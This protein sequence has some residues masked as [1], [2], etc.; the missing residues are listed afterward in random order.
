MPTQSKPVLPRRSGCNRH[1]PSVLLEQ[2][3][4]TLSRARLE[5]PSIRM[6]SSWR[7]GCCATADTPTR[8]GNPAACD[9]RVRLSGFAE[10]GPRKAA[11]PCRGGLELANAGGLRTGDGYPSC[12]RFRFAEPCER[13]DR[14]SVDFDSAIRKIG[15]FRS[16]RE[17]SSRAHYPTRWAVE[18]GY[19]RP[20]RISSRS[21]NGKDTN[22]R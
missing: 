4:R 17:P 8:T 21:M 1:A 16:A 10:G 5:Q 11:R 7:I 14:L 20:R 2:K 13:F 9:A 18:L 15:H 22:E 19:N 6:I 3:L 12:H